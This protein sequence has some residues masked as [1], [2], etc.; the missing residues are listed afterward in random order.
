MGLLIDKSHIFVKPP[1]LKLDICTLI[2]SWEFCFKSI[3]VMYPGKIMK[4]QQQ[5]TG[6]VL[7]VMQT[8]NCAED[9]VEQEGKVLISPIY[10][11]SGPH[12]FSRAHLFGP[13]VFSSTTWTSRWWMNYSS[14]AFKGSS[15][16]CSGFED[17]LERIYLVVGSGKH[18][19]GPNSTIH[20]F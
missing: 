17:T 4:K 19:W 18:R 9:P 13:H 3:L 2:T 11:C 20:H 12:L 16:I 6:A 7:T 14:S 10:L 15:I 5:P 1:K 8:L